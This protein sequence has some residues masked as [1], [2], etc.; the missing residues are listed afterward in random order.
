MLWSVEASVQLNERGKYLLIIYS[1]PLKMIA[2][3]LTSTLISNNDILC[4][5]ENALYTINNQPNNKLKVV[6]AIEYSA[7]KWKS[8]INV[9]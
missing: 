5:V 8:I 7:K 4:P 1:A 3:V 9:C 6:Y 2:E